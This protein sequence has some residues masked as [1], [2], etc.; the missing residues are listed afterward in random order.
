MGELPSLSLFIRQLEYR[1]G[2]VDHPYLNNTFFSG[3]AEDSL[4]KYNI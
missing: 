3:N 4:H 1:A 2:V